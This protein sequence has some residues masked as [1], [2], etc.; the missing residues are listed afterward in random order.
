MKKKPRV[1]I[2]D[3]DLHVLELTAEAVE[4]FGAEVVRA[5]S[6]AELIERLTTGGLFDLILTDISMP[7]ISGLQV[8]HT[9]RAAGIRTPVIVMTALKDAGIAQQVDKLAVGAVLLRKPFAL[10]HLQ[11][12]LRNVLP[13]SEASPATLA[14]H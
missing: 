12:A 8:I 2:A 10:D 9:A 7:W 11:S 6:G 4:A 14:R 13:P 3:D 5:T 1:L